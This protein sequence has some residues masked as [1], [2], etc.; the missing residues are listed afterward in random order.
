MLQENSYTPSRHFVLSMASS[1]LNSICSMRFLTFPLQAIL[2]C[3]H[4]LPTIQKRSSQHIIVTSSQSMSFLS[5]TPLA[6]VSLHKVSTKP[7]LFISSWLLLFSINVTPH[8]ALFIAFSVLKI[9]ISFFFKHHV[10]LPYSIAD[11]TQLQ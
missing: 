6:L 8:I 10:S 2:G 11:L 7:S 3:S 1:F 5:H 4:S 9:A